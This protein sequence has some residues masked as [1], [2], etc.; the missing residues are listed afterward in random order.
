MRF[1]ELEESSRKDLENI[2]HNHSKSYVRQRAQCLLLSNKGYSVPKLA[3]IFSTRTHTVR[4]WFTRWENEGIKG[5]IIRPGRGLK[6][7]I[8]ENDTDF[9]CDL[10]KEISINPHNLSKVVECLNSRWN[11]SLTV[12][13]VK[14]FIKKN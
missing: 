9:V 5:L 6:P 2:Y 14:T 13:Q 8:T 12:R 1:I 3:D 10:Q 7:T 4:D 11:K